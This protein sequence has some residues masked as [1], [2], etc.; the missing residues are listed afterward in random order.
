MRTTCL[1]ETCHRRMPTQEEIEAAI[2]KMPPTIR[3]SLKE[4]AEEVAAGSL[5]PGLEA[6]A[7][8]VLAATA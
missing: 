2:R 8:Q 3:R 6:V 4:S 5:I 7:R 1:D